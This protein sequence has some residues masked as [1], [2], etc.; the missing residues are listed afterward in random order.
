MPAAAMTAL[1]GL[2]WSGGGVFHAMLGVIAVLHALG[3]LH[4]V[5]R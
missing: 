5:S 4:L 1:A 2:V 3:T